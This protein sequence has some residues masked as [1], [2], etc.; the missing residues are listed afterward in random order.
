MRNRGRREGKN[1]I[2]RA[3]IKTAIK[4]WKAT[5]RVN[6]DLTIVSMLSPC[7]SIGVTCKINSW[8]KA[9]IF[10]FSTTA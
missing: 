9:N 8:S 7:S 10:L 4:I 1:N 5:F 3:G 2:N 6:K